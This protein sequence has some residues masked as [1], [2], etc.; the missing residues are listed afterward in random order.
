MSRIESQE[1]FLNDIWNECLTT[2]DTKLYSYFC[3]ITGGTAPTDFIIN[4]TEYGDLDYYLQRNKNKNIYYSIN[5]LSAPPSGRAKAQDIA[6]G[7]CLWLDVDVSGPEHKNANLFPD[8]ITALEWIEQLPLKYSYLVDTGGGFQVYW[9]FE[10]LQEAAALGPLEKSWVQYCQG[11]TDYTLD[12]VHNLDRLFRLPGSYNCKNPGNLRRCY[13]VEHNES[14]YITPEAVF[15][16]TRAQVCTTTTTPSNFE[17]FAQT[18]A[19]IVE[20]LTLDDLRHTLTAI[21]QVLDYYTWLDVGM[22]LHAQTR[23]AAAGLEL[24][25]EFCSTRPGLVPGEPR[26]KWNS[27]NKTDGITWASILSQPKY[28][29]ERFAPLKHQQ[30]GKAAFIK[31]I[32]KLHT[33]IPAPVLTTVL[34][35]TEVPQGV[36]AAV[37]SIVAKRRKTTAINRI[38]N[39]QEIAKYLRNVLYVKTRNMCPYYEIHTKNFIAKANFETF[40][41]MKYK[42]KLKDVQPMIKA[43]DKVDYRMDLEP[44]LF[45]LESRG[46]NGETLTTE[47][48]NLFHRPPIPKQKHPQHDEALAFIRAHYAYLCPGGE[49]D[50]DTIL[51]Y[52]AHV[53]QCKP[54]IRWALVLQGS[55]GNGKSMLSEGL[56]S[57]FKKVNGGSPNHSLCGIVRAKS[58]K[59]E[60]GGWYFGKHFVCLDEVDKLNRVRRE[61]LIENLKTLIT[62]DDIDVEL[63]GRD[64][65]TVKN[66]TNLVINSNDEH[67]LA[68][69]PAER[70][71]CIIQFTASYQDPAFAGDYF[72]RLNSYIKNPDIWGSI[73]GLRK[74]NLDINRPPQTISTVEAKEFG[75]EVRKGKTSSLVRQ[76]IQEIGY[77]LFID[78]LQ[79]V[80]GIVQR[81]L[82]RGDPSAR[83]N[84]HYIATELGRLGY[85]RKVF[86]Y[87]GK[88]LKRYFHDTLKWA[89]KDGKIKSI[90]EA[91]DKRDDKEFRT[92]IGV[93]KY[94][95]SDDFKEAKDPLDLGI[96]TDKNRVIKL[97][98]LDD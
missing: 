13:I 18:E 77:P 33:G 75:R 69:D 65:E 7:R 82:R 34:E 63:K 16:L 41:M 51:D 83:A 94:I 76:A 20:G 60:W 42:I 98:F 48:F 40:L 84:P 58:V 45:T 28:Y 11:L 85:Y 74:V 4:P 73:L 30:M 2:D 15:E 25:E 6:Y 64:V 50:A 62:N 97:P 88:S 68:S 1:K 24:W 31:F 10:D 22:A 70:R 29:S 72:R 38:K 59:K 35:N 8:K 93:Q 44:G 71:L 96:T 55:Y 9:L 19:A 21:N 47:G 67:F 54:R 80:Y 32:K 95:L 57:C 37:K 89:K 17:E 12:R 39:T 27:F 81:E 14:S 78:D 49:E 5:L 92:L 26:A 61:E 86:K 79:T 36:I 56:I 66:M 23:G 3:T 46:F 43:I 87:N 90:A 53:Y 91:Y 52:F